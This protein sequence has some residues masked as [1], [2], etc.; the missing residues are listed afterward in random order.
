[1]FNPFLDAVSGIVKGLRVLSPVLQALEVAALAPVIVLF[2]PAIA[3]FMALA[4]LLEP[5]A[6]S[7]DQL[8][9]AMGKAWEAFV[10]I[11][12]PFEDLGN[13]LANGIGL[14]ASIIET[15]IE[16]TLT[17]L[18]ATLLPWA[19]LLAGPV[20]FAFGLLF[21]GLKLLGEGFL[22]A[23]SAMDYVMAQIAFGIGEILSKVADFLD[24][25][26]GMVEQPEQFVVC[27]VARAA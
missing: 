26:A 7:T 19:Q 15:A 23:V 12:R 24:D 6:R 14:I 5:M 18:A 27:D 17:A 22:M 3:S 4:A 1:M 8:E 10:S 25:L 11:G 20:N 13:K 2:G 21:D 16:P 9:K